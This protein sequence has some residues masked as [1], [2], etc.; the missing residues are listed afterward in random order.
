[1]AHL[2]NGDH[3]M[4][5]LQHRDLRCERKMN[6]SHAPMKGQY[7]SSHAVR[8]VVHFQAT[9]VG[10]LAQSGPCRQTSDQKGYVHQE[11]VYQSSA[12]AYPRIGYHL[13]NP[14]PK[15]SSA[16]SSID[17]DLF[18]IKRGSRFPMNSCSMPSPS[19]SR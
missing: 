16:G 9:N 5:F 15:R 4:S 14:M 7:W 19:Y 18:A 10:V 12:P 13:E 1:V 11:R 6:R 17:D 8:L 3:T 2:L